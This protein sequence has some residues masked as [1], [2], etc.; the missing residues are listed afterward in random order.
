MRPVFFSYHVRGGK[1]RSFALT[2]L[3]NSILVGVSQSCPFDCNI[4]GLLERPLDLVCA[5]RA[6]I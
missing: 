2:G 3:G 4:L 1:Q 6:V 5:I